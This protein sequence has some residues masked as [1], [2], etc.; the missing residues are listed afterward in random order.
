MRFRVQINAFSGP[1]DLLY[2][3][4]RKNELDVRDI[5]IAEIADQFLEM[6]SVLE[7][8]DFDAVGE[9]LELATRLIEIKSQMALPHQEEL[10]QEVDDPRRDLVRRLL[11]YKRFK[12]AAAALDDRRR[13]WQQRFARCST[14][15]EK[16]GV[17]P[18]DQPIQDVELWDLVSA[19]SRVMRDSAA[20]KPASIRYDDTPI[21]AYSEM[22]CRRLAQEARLPFESIFPSAAH[23]SKFIGVFLALLELIRGGL[24]M[25]DQSENFGR[26]WILAGPKLGASLGQDAD[27]QGGA[28]R[29]NSP[30]DDSLPGRR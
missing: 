17:D 15:S 22:I 7:Q 27:A 2:Y 26:L 25:V 5:P 29:A 9:F 18:A 20:A 3:L 19:F 23:R 21:E 12:D 1:L 8:I 4:I 13:Q 11:E 24:V 28:D 30:S 6:S 16:R 14:E 10:E